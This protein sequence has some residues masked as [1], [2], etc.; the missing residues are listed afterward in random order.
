MWANV[1]ATVCEPVPSLKLQIFTTAYRK[2]IET[3]LGP[4]EPGPL[5]VQV[6][7]RDL[8]GK[9]LANGAYYVVLSHESG[10]TLNKILILH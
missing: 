2:V 6:E 10:S 9:P 5:S 4:R 3:D 1:G 7:L 8:K